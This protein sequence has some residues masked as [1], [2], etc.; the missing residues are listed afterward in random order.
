MFKSNYLIFIF[1]FFWTISFAQKNEYNAVAY[2]QRNGLASYNIKSIQQDKYGFMW[3]GTQDG[4][5]FYDGINFR[6]IT[7]PTNAAAVDV[8]KIKYDSARNLMWVAYSFGGFQAFD[9][10]THQPVFTISPLNSKALSN[11]P[12]IQSLDFMAPSKLIVGLTHEF[13]IYDIDLKREEPVIS[14][15]GSSTTENEIAQIATQGNNTY[16]FV[17]NT[18]ICKLSIDQKEKFEW[19]LRDSLIHFKSCTADK[20]NVVWYATST[21]LYHLA[22]NTNAIFFDKKNIEINFINILNGDSLLLS[23]PEGC[24]FYDISNHSLERMNFNTGKSNSSNYN[25]CSFIDNQRHLWLGFSEL[26]IFSDFATP[27]FSGL[28]KEAKSEPPLTHLYNILPINDSIFYLADLA[29]LIYYDISNRKI[30]FIDKKCGIPTNLKNYNDNYIVYNS[31][32]GFW[33]L[34]KKT[35]KI[36][37]VESILPEFAG[38]KKRIIEKWLDVNDSLTLLSGSDKK[39]LITWNKKNHSIKEIEYNIKAGWQDN[40]VN[41]LTKLNDS[42]VIICQDKNI[43]IYNVIRNTISNLTINDPENNSPISLYF[44]C[45]LTKK[46]IVILAYG[47]G[48]YFLDYQFRIKKVINAKNELSNTGVYSLIEDMNGFIWVSTNNGLNRI[49]PEN[50]SV[51]T[52]FEDDGLHNN[53]FEENSSSKYGKKMF[54]GGINGFTSITPENITEDR[55]NPKIYLTYVKLISNAVDTTITCIGQSTI[56]IP[57]YVNQTVIYFASDNFVK[58]PRNKYF[59]KIDGIQDNWVDLGNENKI[60]LIEIKPGEYKLQIKTKNSNGVES[61]ASQ[62]ITIKVEPRWYQ[63][64]WFKLLL[65]LIAITIAFSIYRVRI[66]QLKKEQKI[67]TKLASDLHDDLGSTMNSVKVYASLALMDKQDKYLFKIKESTQEAITGIRDIIWVLDDS[68]D[69]IEHLLS[70]ISQFAAPLCEANRT[71]YV[72][73]ISDEA[74]D[75]KLGQEERRSLYMIMKEAIN[76][77]IKYADAKKI[78]IEVSVKKGKPAI[79][80]NDDGKGFDTVVVNEGNGLKNMHRRAKEIKYEI[81][82]QSQPDRGTAV[83]LEKI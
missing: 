13:F 1:L 38:I 34:E 33:G 57:N 14:I 58:S 68:K 45:L 79:Q 59:Y 30:F 60:S 39:G 65:I 53:A 77:A 29:G 47:H 11:S 74:R 12:N 35:N 50:F 26:L 62:E 56:L 64:W 76:N 54:F 20:K 83:R 6:S 44:D 63:T 18:G 31:L 70:R 51:R 78:E 41:S 5:S 3:I 72:Q 22:T 8:K 43:G 17:E 71:L 67:R 10:Q 49:N 66:N 15:S 28:P 73:E 25:L 52:Y 32:K 55:I 19:I 7:N 27:V 61:I 21:G 37:E 23:T 48:V 36:I 9:C 40:V 42:L 24:F 46:F 82:I 80:I 2:S 75:H 81:N 4:V 69:A 16:I